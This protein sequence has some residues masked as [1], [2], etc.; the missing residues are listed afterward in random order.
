MS[1]M[2]LLILGAVIGANNFSTSLALGALGQERRLWRVLVVF[3]AFEFTVPLVGLWLGQRLASAV[4]GHGGW[5]GPLLLAGLGLWT[6]FEA[7]RRTRDRE[8]LA[9]RL[10]DW[11]GLVLLAAGLSVDNLVVGFG[12]G[13]GGTPPLLMATVIM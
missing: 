1:W 12:L 5:L 2:S 7:T 4:A 8:T 10:T 6:L 9:R 11:R 13:L 3:A